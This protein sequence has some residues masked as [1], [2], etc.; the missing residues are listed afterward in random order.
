[1]LL[2]SDIK[3]QI[4][5]TN[6]F[7]IKTERVSDIEPKQFTLGGK[8]SFYIRIFLDV[9]SRY[10]GNNP[11]ILDDIDLVK[12]H[13]HSSY[14][15]NVRISENKLNNFEIKVWSYGYYRMFATIYPKVGD[16]RV[17]EGFVEFPVTPEEKERNN[18]K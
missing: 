11:L 13:L 7:I 15:Q 6:P 14:K 18:P 17:I 8:F 16:I 3:Q 10:I 5:K 4:S 1:M 9:N 2:L 12:Y